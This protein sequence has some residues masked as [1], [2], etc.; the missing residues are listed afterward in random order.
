QEVVAIAG[1]SEEGR[2]TVGMVQVYPNSRNVVPGE[3]TFS[4]DMR[5]ISDAAVDEMDRQLRA[6]ITRVQQESGLAVTLQEVSH[7][8]A[9]PFHPD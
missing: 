8:P 5:N 7:Y 2:G 3:V 9:A 1:R 6:F 4:I